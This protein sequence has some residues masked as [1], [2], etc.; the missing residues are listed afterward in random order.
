MV[1]FFMG[2]ML[3][4]LI[5]SIYAGTGKD[6]IL[7]LENEIKQLRELTNR[8]ERE[9][10][11]YIEELSKMED[12]EKERL[13]EIGERISEL[14]KSLKKAKDIQEKLIILAKKGID[15]KKLQMEIKNI[16]QSFLKSLNVDVK[17][18][19]MEDAK[20]RLNQLKKEIEKERRY[21]KRKYLPKAD[22]IVFQSKDGYKVKNKEGEILY[23]V[24]D[25]NEGYKAI[26]WA[27]DNAKD[28]SIIFV[29]EGDYIVPS[30]IEVKGKKGIKI[31]SDGAL[32]RFKKTGIKI[33]VSSEGI[34]IAGFIFYPDREGWPLN[35]ASILTSKRYWGIDA[36][37]GHAGIWSRSKDTYIHHNYI[38]REDR[39]GFGGCGIRIGRN[40][41][42]ESNIIIGFW[43]E[44]IAHQTRPRPQRGFKIINNYIARN[45]HKAID[46]DSGGYSIF[47]GN[48]AVENGYVTSGSG[49]IRGFAY[50][51]SDAEG[52]ST[53][54]GGIPR[55]S[56]KGDGYVIMIGNVSMNNWWGAL[57]CAV[58][59][60]GFIV[61]NYLDGHNKRISE[62]PYSIFA[63]GEKIYI[64]GN[65]IKGWVGIISEA[66]K[67]GP[68][69]TVPEGKSFEDTGEVYMLGNVCEDFKV[70]GNNV[71]IFGNLFKDGEKCYIGPWKVYAYGTPW[72]KNINLMFNKITG[73]KEYGLFITPSTILHPLG[74]GFATR[75]GKIENI[76]ILNNEFIEN[77]KRNN[78]SLK[79]ELAILGEFWETGTSGHKPHCQVGVEAPRPGGIPKNIEIVGNIFKTRKDSFV[80][81]IVLAKCKDVLI[82]GNHFENVSGYRIFTCWDNPGLNVEILPGCVGWWKFNEGKGRLIKDFSGYNNDGII[83]EKAKWVKIKNNYVLKLDG[84]G[85]VAFKGDYSL[86]YIKDGITISAWMYPVKEGGVYFKSYSM[87]VGERFIGKVTLLGI[88]EAK[89]ET[90]YNKQNGFSHFAFT[91]SSYDKKLCLYL[92]GKLV[93]E[94]QIIITNPSLAKIELKGMYSPIYIGGYYGSK[95]FY[96]GLIGEV[97]IYNRALSS[98]EI[99]KYYEKTKYMYQ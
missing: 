54:I 82:L 91:Y 61:G 32:I 21:L 63:S 12:I 69:G 73:M 30:Q 95:S 43:G 20:K 72:A 19:T 6:E 58:Y 3:F 53:T 27:I 9:V 79:I 15:T 44:G 36:S 83:R 65:R 42:V 93:K 57:K 56:S 76:L 40:E 75:K 97:K 34:E 18:Y 5:S 48:W 84:E 80:N 59:N 17:E 13:E 39:K 50:R 64:L 55:K 37:Y 68:R 99:R 1:R 88:P 52:I 86:R 33:D 89:I 77:E 90:K 31:F 28:N 81:G 98:E 67:L 23:K 29:K 25:K 60:Y 7:E 66:A 96:K 10:K 26:Q 16:T 24:E 35:F 71:W 38:G 87:V 8:F 94:K 14:G 85:F 2:L 70:C 22:F 4:F 45:G 11:G 47:K 46:C 74:Q 62:P 78:E 49:E 92:N 41:R 51:T